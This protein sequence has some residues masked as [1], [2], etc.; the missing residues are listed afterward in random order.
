MNTLLAILQGSE[1]EFSLELHPPAT[2]PLSHS[3]FLLTP[4]RALHV[5]FQELI[6]GTFLLSLVP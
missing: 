4:H 2:L 5:L 3:C 1:E 6:S